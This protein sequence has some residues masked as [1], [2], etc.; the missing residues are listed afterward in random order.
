M[1]ERMIFA[2][3]QENFVRKLSQVSQMRPQKPQTEFK[4]MKTPST[5]EVESTGKRD[6]MTEGENVRGSPPINGLEYEKSKLKIM[7]SLD[8]YAGLQETSRNT[9]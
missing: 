3:I 5:K 9:F 7:N 4:L 1:L 2:C 6:S 8:N